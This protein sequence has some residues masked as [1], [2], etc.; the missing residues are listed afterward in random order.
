MVIGLLV[1]EALCSATEKTFMVVWVSSA[2]SS[3][4]LALQ[5]STL[6]VS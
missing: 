3:L 5:E 2:P 1:M 4:A 6:T